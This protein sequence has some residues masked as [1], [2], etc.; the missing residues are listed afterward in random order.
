MSKDETVV[1]FGKSDALANL[2]REQAWHRRAAMQIVL[3]LPE[4]PDDARMV[5]DAA[6]RLLGDYINN[7]T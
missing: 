2:E 5:L 6:G 1:P 3:Q 4:K 7:G